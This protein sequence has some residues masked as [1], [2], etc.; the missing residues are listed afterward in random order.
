MAAPRYA[1]AATLIVLSWR[2]A[3]AADLPLW[4]E[5]P[6]KAA[7]LDFVADVTTPDTDDF[8]PA[9]EWI[10][11]FDNDGTLW[12]Q[13]PMCVQGVFAF[14]RL[15]ALAP[16]HP[17]W[18][19]Q[20]LFK[21]APQGD[22]AT[23][24]DA[25]EQGLVALV[26]ATHAGMTTDAVAAE[27][28]DWLATTQHPR[29]QRPY[30]R[31]VYQPMVE[32]ADDG[33]GKPAGIHRFIGRRPIAAFGNSDGDLQMLRWATSALGRRF[34]L[35]VHHDDSRREF[36]YDRASKIGRLDRALDAA[37]AAGWFVVSMA[38]DWNAIF[39]EAPR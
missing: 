31:L 22:R 4:N 30:L 35:I 38:T 36:A 18:Q 9:A 19:T 17:E 15:R 33:P 37:G 5:G 23:L 27:V 14:D 12:V 32:F 21:A 20:Q 24:T 11:V 16:Q 28:T 6:A 10:A 25:G 34:G 1:L 2:A 3:G 39:P 13:Q 26:M 29:S 7:I 8:V